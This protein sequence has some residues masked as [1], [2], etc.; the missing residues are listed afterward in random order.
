[1]CGSAK[2]LSSIN[3]LKFKNIVL[4]VYL[5][6]DLDDLKMDNVFQCADQ[7]VGPANHLFSLLM[8]TLI[9]AQCSI[10]PPDMWPKDY[11]PIAIENGK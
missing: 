10:S 8:Q 1:M 4:L 2:R 3:K 6:R 9:Q 7:S 5:D 11:G